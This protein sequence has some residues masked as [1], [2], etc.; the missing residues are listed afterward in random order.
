MI[1]IPDTDMES[2]DARV[3]R[4]KQ[5]AHIGLMV[6]DYFQASQHDALADEEQN[7]A[8]VIRK[9]NSEKKL[10]HAVAGKRK[11]HEYAHDVSSHQ[12]AKQAV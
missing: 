10:G 11:D 4:S 9:T 6:A 2:V 7:T 3:L 1:R 12:K 5:N 8:S